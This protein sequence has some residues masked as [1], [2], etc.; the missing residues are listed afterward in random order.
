[1]FE[2]TAPSVTRTDPTESAAPTTVL[3]VDDH[4]SFA[5]LLAE[6]LN[7]VPGGG[8]RHRP[9]RPAMGDPSRPGWRI[10]LHSQGRDARRDDRSAQPGQARPDAD[11]V[12]HLPQ[13][14]LPAG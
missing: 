10:Y 11:R 7:N 1:M 8:H 6:A 12:D 5:E 4:R 3:I 2:G 14:A 13:P 9:P